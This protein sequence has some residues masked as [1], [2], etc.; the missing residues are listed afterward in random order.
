VPLGLVAVFWRRQFKPVLQA[1]LPQMPTN[2][3]LDGLGFVKEVYRRIADLSHLDF[4]VA[5]RLTGQNALLL[6]Q[7]ITDAVLNIKVMPAKHTS[8][9]NGPRVYGITSGHRIRLAREWSS[10]LIT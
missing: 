6:H 7:A 5:A 8:F 2:H 4:R 9:P 1:G 10:I 3:G